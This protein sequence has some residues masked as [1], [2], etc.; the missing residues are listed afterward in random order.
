MISRLCQSLML[1]AFEDEDTARVARV[2]N[3]ILVLLFVGSVAYL[4]IV[5]FGAEEMRV[6][7]PY[8]LLIVFCM[9]LLL[10]LLRLGYVRA[11]GLLASLLLWL[12]ITFYSLI[13]PG[14][15]HPVLTAQVLV[16][17]I[18]A[19]T[20]GSE[21]AIGFAILSTLS[22]VGV[23]YLDVQG[24]LPPPLFAVSPLAIVV[25]QAFILMFVAVFLSLVAR[26]MQAVLDRARH[27]EQVLAERNA[28]LESEIA[29]RR[30]TEA[31]RRASEARLRLATNA[32]QIGIWEW[33]LK[34][35]TIVWDEL[36][37]QIFGTAP[38]YTPDNYEVFSRMIHPEDLPL[39]NAAIQAT[40]QRDEPF[41]IE[42][43]IVLADGSVRWILEQAQIIYDES[44]APFSLLGMAQDISERKEAE[45]QRLALALA[46]ERVMLLH[47]FIGNVSH[48]LKNP[49]AVINTS[50]YLL[51]RMHEPEH[52]HDKI[53]S[54]KEQVQRLEN[55]I[56]NI[57]A[58]SRLDYL[59]ETPREPVDLNELAA[60][61]ERRLRPAV[62][63]KRQ[64]FLLELDPDLPPVAGI[65]SELY[66]MVMNLAENAVQYTPD[67]GLVNIITRPAQNDVILEVADSGIGIDRDDLPHIF[68]RFFRSDETR[69]TV[70][71]G[72]GLG[73][74]IVKRVV[75]M[76]NGQISVDSQIGAGT[77]FVVR[78][79]TGAQ[80][81]TQP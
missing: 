10:A 47:D 41:S 60:D 53:I 32:A 64:V 50:L 76:H 68:E 46:Q 77:R 59:E 58:L 37:H 14:M 52:Q 38:D 48:D 39:L 8:A 62:E 21:A 72:S 23:Y 69:N 71:S 27:D 61:V 75:E 12:I 11:V 49:L 18:A 36:V 79:P 7:Q 1:P 26:S 30:K 45:E 34:D 24:V 42:F 65:S 44:G 20:L 63:K 74:A 73:L 70:R 2:L 31:A 16:I 9:L 4:S 6:R 35:D 78:L 5:L 80:V 3:R 13:S 29:E 66:R 28:E 55:M 81:Q 25:T 22:A 15:E 57:L 54:I 43:R 19:L 17:V 51:E 33:N 56:Q 40:I 67:S